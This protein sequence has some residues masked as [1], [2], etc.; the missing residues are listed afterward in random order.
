M[1]VSGQKTQVQ[2]TKG[3]K[4]VP[5]FRGKSGFC[6]CGLHQHP[7]GDFTALCKAS[8]ALRMNGCVASVTKC[9]REYL[10]GRRVRADV[11]FFCATWL[12]LGNGMKNRLARARRSVVCVQNSLFLSWLQDFKV[13]DLNSGNG[14]SSPIPSD[15]PYRIYILIVTNGGIRPAVGISFEHFSVCAVNLK[16]IVP[17][18]FIDV[19]KFLYIGI[20]FHFFIPPLI[21]K[22]VVHPCHIEYERGGPYV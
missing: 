1:G 22:H 5:G 7:E 17:S 12:P 6:C 9:F 19:D 21:G 14:I 11:L 13:A 3:A 2:L 20:K 10:S 8:D 18:N 15:K 4:T 16:P